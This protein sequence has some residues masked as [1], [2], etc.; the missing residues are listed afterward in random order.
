MGQLI[1]NQQGPSN[2]HVISHPCHLSCHVSLS[3][4]L[5]SSIMFLSAVVIRSLK[6]LGF[7]YN[8]RLSCKV[9]PASPL[10]SLLLQ[11]EQRDVLW[12]V[13][14]A[15]VGSLHIFL[16]AT[17]ESRHCPVKVQTQDL[18]TSNVNRMNRIFTLCS[19]IRC[20]PV[21]NLRHLRSRRQ[22]LQLPLGAVTKAQIAEFT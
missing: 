13:G 19:D 10:R 18:R 5:L 11:G 12:N 17:S 15:G 3:Y 22:T 9:V 21:M 20:E 1:G 6:L 2:P 14:L 8:R 16:R 4:T 7:A